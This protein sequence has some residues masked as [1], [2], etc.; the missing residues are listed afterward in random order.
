LGTVF[1]HKVEEEKRVG[2]ASD[3]DIGL[4]KEPLYSDVDPGS[5]DGGVEAWLMVLG[6][7]NTVVV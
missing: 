4:S 5:P 7:S 3:I 6:V 1:I 2:H